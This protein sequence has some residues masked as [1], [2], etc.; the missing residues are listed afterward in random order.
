MPTGERDPILALEAKGHSHH[1]ACRLVWGDGECECGLKDRE[2]RDAA[3]RALA[4]AVEDY[5]HMEKFIE[6]KKLFRA[7]NALIALHEPGWPGE[8]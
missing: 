7:Q 1:C 5:R 6:Y 8:E 4:R 2:T 3:I